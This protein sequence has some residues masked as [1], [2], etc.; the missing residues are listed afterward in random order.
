MLIIWDTQT[1]VVINRVN[2]QDY[3]RI[4]FHGDQRT[5]TLITWG[6]HLYTYDA[7]NGK[8]LSLG[9]I[10]SF[11][12]YVLSTQW[13]H[14]DTFLSVIFFETDGEPVVRIY[15]FQP[16]LTP[17]V[18]V[19]SSFFMPSGSFTKWSHKFSFSS[20]SSH[21]SLVRNGSIY[22]FDAQKKNP[23]SI[24]SGW[25][26]AF[27]P[28][29]HFFAHSTSHELYVQH[30]TPTGYVQWN[31]SKLRLYLNYLSWSPTS[32]QILCW[33]REGIQMIDLDNYLIPLSPNKMQNSDLFQP[34]NTDMQS[35]DIKIA[36]NATFVLNVLEA[37]LYHR[38]MRITV[39]E[40]SVVDVDIGCLMSSH[41]NPQVIF[42]N[43]QED[44]LYNIK[45][46]KTI[47][48]DIEKWIV[49]SLDNRHK[50]WSIKVDHSWHYVTLVGPISVNGEDFKIKESLSSSLYEYEV[51][52]GSGWVVDSRGK[53]VLWLP[54]NWRNRSWNRV[55]WGSEYLGM[56]HPEAIL[57]EF[58][59]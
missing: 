58:Q 51:R 52:Y 24:G 13:T 55:R 37:N 23:S 35:L 54:P 2:T 31:C 45:T 56:A 42:I 4:N 50:L 44:F 12:G 8:Q 15:E 32:M 40:A 29:G 5:I 3:G 25:G 7:L 6:S 16:A 38:E 18:S 49:G 46:Q 48:K 47:P 27:S 30:N 57:I 39:D 33:G 20:V 26:H 17:P 1:G 9:Q 53:K 59:Q 43:G 21:L 10:P 14:K 22:L 36:D 19:L 41:D 34:T 11:E 28:N